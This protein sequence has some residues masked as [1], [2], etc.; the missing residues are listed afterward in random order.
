MEKNNQFD[1]DSKKKIKKFN[2]T[3]LISVSQGPKGK[4]K[5]SSFFLFF[6]MQSNIKNKILKILRLDF[7]FFH[8]IYLL[9]KNNFLI[10]KLSRIM[11]YL[12][13]YL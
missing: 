7:S 11:K 10:K 1:F 13:Y 12:F 4:W 6:L 2:S 9:N 8:R 5:Y 3:N